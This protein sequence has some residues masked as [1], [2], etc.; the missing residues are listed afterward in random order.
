MITD[1]HLV[2]SWQLTKMS[3]L[4]FSSTFSST[5]HSFS[6]NDNHLLFFAFLCRLWFPYLYQAAS[7]V[8]E[9]DPVSF[10]RF[11]VVG[12]SQ[13]VC[14]IAL[15]HRQLPP[16]IIYLFNSL[17]R[18]EYPPRPSAPALRHKL[19]LAQAARTLISKHISMHITL[20][21][22]NMARSLSH[23]TITW[24]AKRNNGQTIASLSIQ[25]THL[26]ILEVCFKRNILYI[27]S[28]IIL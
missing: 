20:L 22:H 10:N 2:T 12:Y 1:D 21:G 7:R 8:I 15:F 17:L 25:M 24:Q 6:F 14:L 9:Q 19:R 18:Q 16:L 27:Y 11:L 13:P 5:P 4:N 3:F 28:L 26:D 23:G